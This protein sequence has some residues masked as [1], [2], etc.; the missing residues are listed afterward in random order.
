MVKHYITVALRLIK[1]SFLFST[2]NI[3]GFILG[4][5]AA[6]L[7]YLWVVDELT[8]EDFQK[9]KDSIYRVIKVT[10]DDGGKITE[11]PSVLAPLA[12][13]FRSG[14]DQVEN[15]TFIKHE[16]IKT[17]EYNGKPIEGFGVYVDSCFFDVFSF[18]VVAG[19]PANMKNDPQQIVITDKMA[20]KLF[21]KEEAVG[22][23][24]KHELYSRATYYTVAAVVKMP[25]K[26]HIH[27]DY[28]FPKAAYGMEMNWRFSENILV[29]V[30]MRGNGTMSA[31]ERLA[32]NRVWADNTGEKV[33][34]VFQP[35]KD[36]HL[37]TKFL[38]PCVRNHG[39]MSQ[40]YLFSALAVLVIFMGAFN[41]TTLST[42][43]ASM[44]YKEIGVRKVT[45]AKR[46]TLIFQFLSESM[47]QAFLSLVLALALTELFLPF[48]NRMVDKDISLQVSWQVL[49]FVLLGI[50]GV[51][52]LAG[53][54]PAFYLSSINP[55]L[56][57]KGG[58]KT[59]RKGGFVK[60]L[61]CVQFTIAIVLILCT[62]IAFKQLNYIQNKD[63]GMDKENIVMLYT[64]L[65]YGVDEFKREV[66]R[67]PN[68]KSVA[69]GVNMSDYMKGGNADGKTVFWHR[70]DGSLDSLRMVTMFGDGDFIKT[71]DIELI[72]GE[73]F[74]ADASAYW[75]QTYEF[76][77]VINETAWKMMKEENPVG[78]TLE[79]AVWGKNAKIV[80]VVKDFNFQSLR[81]TIK[82]A[83]VVFS[84]EAITFLYIRIAPENKQE[85]LKFLQDT[86]AK[87][88]SSFVRSFS[89]KFY[90]DALN[91]NY[92]TEQQQSRVFLLFTILAI[93][94]SM[95]GVFGLVA[96]ST[97]Q[98]TKEIGVRKVIGAHTDRVVK[99]FCF[100][101]MKWIGIA[102]LIAC[103]VG[104]LLMDRWLSS[105]AYQTSISWWLFP[106]AG[107]IILLITLLTVIV[108]IY[109]TASQNPV[110]SLR[111][112]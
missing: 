37:R 63:L 50:F 96:L 68:V 103:P 94:I 15:A 20:E 5:S 4:I 67:N 97:A 48:F 23:Q 108:Q 18:P 109:R 28:V 85:T 31:N 62:S 3:L 83:Y 22:K 91:S 77:T 58:K 39:N 101:Y 54:Y 44:R 46:K 90:S 11:S 72:Q 74:D 36:I 53:S 64:S 38:D 87:T 71:F 57:F 82:P 24:L 95:M 29:Y 2:I 49:L 32:M 1:R 73:L 65:W 75:N 107:L 110:H 12:E 88:N 26:T 52:C 17:L 99:M 102:F 45:G 112:E 100:E 9:N 21:G 61:V 66:L 34:L 59:G 86:Y 51:G 35:L 55:L 84:P 98:R 80:G 70:D 25:R 56:A 19:N 6:F 92:Q 81:E 78:K 42:A 14:F 89:Y 16:S 30:Q 69:M 33:A 40:I 104:Y 7:I 106:I 111:Y 10:Q 105:F 47:V 79:K 93:L 8:F 76:P 41:F 60:G 43:R 27:F 13:A